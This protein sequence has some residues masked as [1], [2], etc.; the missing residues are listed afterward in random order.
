MD[1]ALQ[2]ANVE[3]AEK[4]GSGRLAALRPHPVPRGTFARLRERAV[5][6]GT[7]DGQYKD[8]ILALTDAAWEH[9]LACAQPLPPGL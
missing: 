4:R 5:A 6:N 3:Y 2:S 7:P 1:L 9:L 8:P